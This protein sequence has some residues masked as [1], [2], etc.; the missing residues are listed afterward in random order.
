MQ[1]QKK[2]IGIHQEI[3]FSEEQE[4]R[5]KT[6]EERAMAYDGKS[7]ISGSMGRIT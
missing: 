6:L 1:G 7:N 4:F 5:H 2:E 3:E